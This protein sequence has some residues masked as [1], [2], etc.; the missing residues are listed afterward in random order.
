MR[1]DAAFSVK[2]ERG[3]ARQRAPSISH[4]SDYRR[5]FGGLSAATSWFL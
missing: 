2:K 3:K 4:G 1:S 5:V